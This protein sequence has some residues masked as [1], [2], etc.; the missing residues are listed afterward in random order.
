M[1]LRNSSK[2]ILALASVSISISSLGGCAKSCQA[3]AERQYLIMK[4]SAKGSFDDGWISGYDEVSGCDS[5]DDPSVT[6]WLDRSVNSLDEVSS[7]MKKNKWLPSS[8]EAKA[9]RTDHSRSSYELEK[10][11]EGKIVFAIL[12]DGPYGRSANLRIGK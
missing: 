6:V 12:S 8:K 7:R 9:S 2:L 11:V 10:K 3:E 4:E 1:R 5:G